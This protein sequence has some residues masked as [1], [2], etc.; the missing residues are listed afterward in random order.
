MSKLLA[1]DNF[2]TGNWSLEIKN[3]APNYADLFISFT[4]EAPIVEFKNLRFGYELKQEG[5]IKKYNMFPKAGA[6]YIRSDQ[7]YLVV[8]RLHFKPDQT[9][10][11]FLWAENGGK[12]FEKEFEITTPRPKQPYPSWIWNGERWN[13]PTPYPEDGLRYRWNEETQTWVEREQV[14]TDS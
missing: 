7:P 10:T 14:T 6:R 3:L 8:E 12:R 4:N 1:T 9:Y 11:L 13:A 2:K 5:N